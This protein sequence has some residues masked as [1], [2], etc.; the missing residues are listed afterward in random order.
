M[1]IPCCNQVRFLG[2]AIEGVL[3]RSHRRFEIVAVDDGST[4]D[5]SEVDARYPPSWHRS[6]RPSVGPGTSSL[7]KSSEFPRR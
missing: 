1:V 5:T 4:D 7:A 2:E 6:P 3:A